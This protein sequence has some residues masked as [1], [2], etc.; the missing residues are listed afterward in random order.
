MKDFFCF[1]CILAFVPFT[2]TH[3]KKKRVVSCPSKG[4]KFDSFIDWI[5][6]GDWSRGTWRK[7]GVWEVWSS[8]LNNINWKKSQFSSQKWG[9][10]YGWKELLLLILFSLLLLLLLLY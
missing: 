7:F 4:R 2:H 5:L 1:L 9:I 8:W 3:K 6:L 10:K